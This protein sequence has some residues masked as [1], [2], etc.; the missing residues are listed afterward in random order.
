[1][2]VGMLWFDNDPHTS[3]LGKVQRAVEYYRRKYGR[4]PNLCL[5]HPTMLQE[6]AKSA[7]QSGGAGNCH[8]CLSRRPAR[9]FLDRDRRGRTGSTRRQISLCGAAGRRL[10]SPR[11]QRRLIAQG[12]QHR[13]GHS[14]GMGQAE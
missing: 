8:P 1:M 13:Q 12:N 2:N 3:L 9:P 14:L 10:I 6:R 7:C 5:V 11:S 4:E